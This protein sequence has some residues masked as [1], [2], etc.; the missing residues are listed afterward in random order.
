MR[1]AS[2]SSGEMFL[3]AL[4]TSANAPCHQYVAFYDGWLPVHGTL[5]GGRTRAQAHALSLWEEIGKDK[6]REIKMS[7]W[8]VTV[9]HDREYCLF[10]W[11]WAEGHWHHGF[12]KWV[13]RP[14]KNIH[15]QTRW[16]F[17]SLPVAVTQMTFCAITV[18]C[19]NI[20]IS[21]VQGKIT[22]LNTDCASAMT[23]YLGSSAVPCSE[24]VLFCLHCVSMHISSHSKVMWLIKGEG[25]IGGDIRWRTH[26]TSSNTFSLS[27]PRPSRQP[28]WIGVPSSSR[29]ALWWHHL[30]LSLSQSSSWWH[31]RWHLCQQE[32]KAVCLSAR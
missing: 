21:N 12:N 31:L 11:L 9:K 19:L 32:M 20:S 10:S 5:K 23:A 3:R 15:S 18:L 22:N 7:N 14:S 8:R 1:E 26:H 25:D 4:G 24:S 17:I 2:H 29:V 13:L 16:H 6:M 30:W 27:V 28:H